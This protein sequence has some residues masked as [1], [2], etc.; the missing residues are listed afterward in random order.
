[1]VV[2]AAIAQGNN[3]RGKCM[4]PFGISFYQVKPG[5][6][7]EWLALY[8]TWHYPLLEY[9]LEHGTLL[10][11]RLYVP[12]GHGIENAWTFAASF[13]APAA[14]QAGTA[15]LDRAGLIA[16]LFGDVMDEYVAGEQRRWELTLRHWDTDFIELDK[17]ETPLSVYRPSAGGC[18]SDRARRSERRRS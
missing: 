6:E 16:Q 12:D 10:E 9:A 7:D 2:S 8:M 5:F 18:Q 3:G 11:H 17:S 13:L 4:Q 1:M 15:P 14:G